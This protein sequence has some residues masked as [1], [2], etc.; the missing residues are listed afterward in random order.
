MRISIERHTHP[1]HYGSAVPRSQSVPASAIINLDLH[2]IVSDSHP[3]SSSRP[4]KIFLIPNSLPSC[5]LRHF[6]FSVSVFPFAPIFFLP[7]VLFRSRYDSNGFHSGVFR[8]QFSY[9]SSYSIRSVFDYYVVFYVFFSTIVRWF[10]LCSI[11]L[12]TS[13]LWFILHCVLFSVLILYFIFYSILFS[14]VVM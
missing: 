10:M 12:S 4:L 9:C 2:Y 13:I 8:F 3:R 14:I 7:S 6:V 1:I 11:L 5:F